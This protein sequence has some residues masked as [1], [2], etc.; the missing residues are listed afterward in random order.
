MQSFNPPFWLRNP[1]ALTIMS[2]LLPW[3]RK[4]PEGSTEEILVQ[5]DIHSHILIHC[6]WQ[7]DPTNKYTF[8]LVHG[9]EGS[10][11]SFYMTGLAKS[12]LETQNN[13]VRVNLRSCGNTL[14][15]TPGLYHAGQT[16][17]LLCLI[18]FL[19]EQRGLNKFFLVGFSLGGNIVLKTATELEK[20]TSFLKGICAVAPSIDLDLCVT[21]L[22]KGFNCIYSVR[23]LRSLKRKVMKKHQLAPENF[24]ISPLAQIKSIRQFDDIYTARE[25][26]YLNASHYY[27]EASSL[28]CLKNITVPTQIIAAQDDPF[29]PFEQFKNIKTKY[30]NLIAPKYGGHLGFIPDIRNPIYRKTFNYWLDNQVIHFCLRYSKL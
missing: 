18:D 27:R 5:V 19:I 11:N 28:S 8:I 12:I 26:G 23:F 7:P 17:D 22:E 6:H 13:V 3:G 16:K 21:A 9:L 14:H 1:H 24:D 4:L 20:R 30:I 15:L 10:S 29:I 2:S 25:G